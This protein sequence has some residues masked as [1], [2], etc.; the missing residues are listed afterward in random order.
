MGAEP[1][2]LLSYKIVGGVEY[3]KRN[4][5]RSNNWNNLMIGV[6]QALQLNSMVARG[7]GTTLLP[8]TGVQGSSSSGIDTSGMTA[9]E[10]MNYEMHGIIPERYNSGS[11]SALQNL[12]NMVGGC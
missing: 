7:V 10:K 8:N 9:N 12:P 3:G 6:V 4:I 1:P 11:G 2:Y 5:A